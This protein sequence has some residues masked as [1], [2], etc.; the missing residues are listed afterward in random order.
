MSPM[1]ASVAVGAVLGAVLGIAVFWLASRGAHA[2]AFSRG[3]EQG[4][5]ALAAARERLAALDTE[6][7]A[8]K[9]RVA[10]LESQLGQERQ[11]ADELGSSAA[12]L[13]AQVKERTERLDELRRSTTE[14]GVAADQLRKELADKANRLAQLEILLAEERKQGAERLALLEEAKVQLKAEFENL[15]SRIFDDKSQKFTDQS[16]TNL[17][18]LLNPLREKIDEF[19]RRL[20]DVHTNETKDRQALFHQIKALSDLN[21][22]ISRDAT[23]LTNALKGG[24]KTQ[25]S[26]GE[27]VLARALEL[28]GLQKGVEYET[29]VHSDTDEDKA[30][31]PDVVVHLPEG[32]DVIV[33]SKVSLTAYEESVAAETDDLRQQAINQHLVSVYRHIDELSEKRYEDLPGVKSLDFVLM[34]MPIEA[35]FV[36]AIRH[37]PQVFDYAYKNRVI[38]VCPSTLL[39]TLRTIQNMWRYENQNK[40]VEVIVKRATSL[41]DKFVGFVETLEKVGKAIDAASAQHKAAIGQLATGKGSLVSRVQRFRELHVAGK[42]ELPKALL[43]LADETADA[44]DDG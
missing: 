6:T 3:L 13:S 43:E 27:M 41:Y 15:A 29:E 19:R 17:E 7:S 20:D 23:N 12:T 26:W 35:A 9:S 16:K 34:F 39:V 22:Q 33:D 31:R 21:Q 10:A 8:L 24:S 2:A 42:K 11:R 37:D 5:K 36:A 1:L 28:S 32:R 14:Q 4:A 40:Y 18:T 25:G 30:Y 38:I 44:D